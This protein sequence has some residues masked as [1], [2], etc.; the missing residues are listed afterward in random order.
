[1]KQ[2]EWIK[3]VKQMRLELLCF[4]LTHDYFNEGKI[5]GYKKIRECFCGKHHDK[6]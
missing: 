3:M 2:K 5:F 6:I 1:M 4:Y